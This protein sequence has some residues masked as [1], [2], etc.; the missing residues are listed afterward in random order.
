M[1]MLKPIGYYES[2]IIQVEADYENL[3][4]S[5]EKFKSNT[6]DRKLFSELCQD[7]SYLLQNIKYVEKFNQ[8]ISGLELPISVRFIRNLKETKI[9]LSKVKEFLIVK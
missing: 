6:P 8:N 1:N 5:F 3:K 4:R 2:L 9:F 7:Y